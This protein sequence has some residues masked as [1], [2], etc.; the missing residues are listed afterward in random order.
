MPRHTCIILLLA[1]VSCAHPQVDQAGVTPQVAP[2]VPGSDLVPGTNPAP[3][4][5]RVPMDFN[6]LVLA[7]TAT[8]HGQSAST[9]AIESALADIGEAIAS[10]P[11]PC[12][13]C[14][15]G[16]SCDTV[17]GECVEDRAPPA[18]PRTSAVPPNRGSPS[19][20][21]V[22]VDRA[23]TETSNENGGSLELHPSIGKLQSLITENTLRIS[24]QTLQDIAESLLH[25][26]VTMIATRTNA[27]GQIGIFLK[28]PGPA[29]FTADAP[30][31]MS[32]ACASSPTL[33][34]D[35]PEQRVVLICVGTNQ[36][37]QMVK[38][39]AIREQDGGY[40]IGWGFQ[41]ALGTLT[42]DPATTPKAV[43]APTNAAIYIFARRNSGHIVGMVRYKERPWNTITD[44]DF[45]VMGTRVTHP[46]YP[47]TATLDHTGREV[48]VGARRHLSDDYDWFLPYNTIYWR[49]LPNLWGHAK[50]QWGD[51]LDTSGGITQVAARQTE[52][53]SA[54][55]SP[56]FA[57]IGKSWN[58]LIGE[59]FFTY[60]MV[61]NADYPDQSKVGHKVRYDDIHDWPWGVDK[62]FACGI[63]GTIT[64]VQLSPT[65]EQDLTDPKQTQI[66]GG[67]SN[68]LWYN[69]GHLGAVWN[70][71]LGESTIFFA[72]NR[73]KNLAAPDASGDPDSQDK[74]HKNVL[75]VLEFQSSSTTGT[76]RATMH[77]TP[78]TMQVGDNPVATFDAADP[79]TGFFH[80]AFRSGTNLYVRS[81]NETSGWGTKDAD[82][83]KTIKLG[84]IG[85]YTTGPTQ[86]GDDTLQVVGQP[87]IVYLGEID[88]KFENPHGKLET[89]KFH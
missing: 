63:L 16:T 84:G 78:E 49:L 76:Q 81:W 80:I 66:Q 55:V 12:D 51:V 42:L 68:R 59:Q 3:I 36:R 73:M 4:A 20:P 48:W 34:Y 87:A 14:P 70:P 52:W 67:C 1:L 39:M 89:K 50:T 62:Y 21:I 75:S 19:S 11:D 82:N 46:E 32:P 45:R 65:G 35:V 40:R 17:T 5:P 7:P 18:Q 64:K 37:L 86:I 77:L 13:T 57:R 24:T 58:M 61:Y 60:D 10:T 83:I 2:T 31:T 71:A 47:I 15:A 28:G 54:R 74:I 88:G 53:Y 23:E 38:G 43:F 27:P 25:A 26:N 33:V 6:T 79:H 69:F 30:K 9:M 72:A 44:G 85:R 8:G 56:A 29:T 41:Y 22:G